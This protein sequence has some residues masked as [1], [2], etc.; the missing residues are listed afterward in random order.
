MLSPLTQVLNIINFKFKGKYNSPMTFYPTAGNF[1]SKRV[2]NYSQNDRLI[3]LIT[4]LEML[5]K[6][7]L[8]LTIAHEWQKGRTWLVAQEVWR[9]LLTLLARDYASWGFGI[10]TLHWCLSSF[11]SVTNSVKVEL[12]PETFSHVLCLLGSTWW[13]GVR[14]SLLVFVG[15]WEMFQLFPFVL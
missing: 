4:D 6:E 1:W 8:A 15:I 11:I 12:Y 14:P 7:S 9:V 5:L 10:T 2:S 13:D 3:S